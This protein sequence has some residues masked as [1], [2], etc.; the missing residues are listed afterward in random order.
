MERY[1]VNDGT[2]IRYPSIANLM[3]DSADR[4]LDNYPNAKSFSIQRPNS[5]LNGMFTRVATTEVVFEWN[6][7]NIPVGSVGVP[8]VLLQYSVANAPGGGYQDV[9]TVPTG[10]YTVEEL[11][12]VLVNTLNSVST[13]TGVTWT[14]APSTA[15]GAIL[16][17][18][19]TGGLINIANDPTSAVNIIQ[20][21]FGT[22]V[23]TS[24]GTVNSLATLT[25]AIDLRLYRYVDIISNTLTYAQ[26]VKDASTSKVVRDVLCRWYFDYDEQPYLDLYGYPILMGYKPFF[27][28]RIYNPPKQIKWDNNLPVPGV[29]DFAL[30]TPLGTLAAITDDTNY[31]MTLQVSEN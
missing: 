18:A 31:L 13:A 21:L 14:V 10:F 7:P 12:N 16:S 15:G 22:S 11:V 24:A 27:L 25:T 20:K 9:L 19:G 5:L 6:T 4:N 8:G 2:T 23:V 28:R 30:Y 26:R 1:G 17:R 29:V 3:V